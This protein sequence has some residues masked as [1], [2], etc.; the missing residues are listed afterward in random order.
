MANSNSGMGIHPKNPAQPDISSSG[1]SSYSFS[2]S[3]S[4]AAYLTCKDREPNSGGLIKT[5]DQG[6]EFGPICC[7]DHDGGSGSGRRRIRDDDGQRWLVVRN[8]SIRRGGRR[9]KDEEEES[10]SSTSWSSVFRSFVSPCR[11]CRASKPSAV[12][13]AQAHPIQRC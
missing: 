8:N 9:I 13:E 11:E 10:S 4:F 3:L 5:G 12:I 6:F 2:S 7:D 1:S